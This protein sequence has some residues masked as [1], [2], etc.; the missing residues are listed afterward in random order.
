[1]EKVLVGLSGGV[2]SSVCA[3]LLKQKG[4]EVIGA[5]MKLLDGDISDIS[6]ICSKLDI[7]YRELNYTDSFKKD[8]IDYFANEYNEDFLNAVSTFCSVNASSI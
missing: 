1:M 7:E 2:D 6:D 3:L 4:Y 8:V 5:T